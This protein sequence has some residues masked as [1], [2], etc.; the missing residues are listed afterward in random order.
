VGADG[1]D[2]AFFHDGDAVGAADGREAMGDH[3]DSP[4]L[5]K[6]AEGDLDEGFAFGVEG[7]GGF[8]EDEDGAFLRMARAMAMRCFSPREAEAF[9]AD[10]GVVTC[11]MRRMKSWARAVRAA[12]S[13]RSLE[14]SG[15]P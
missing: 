3:D 11:G 7:R 1:G 14:V 15:C 13:T 6:V 5:H 4:A 8:V 10:D 2:A 9:F 12:C